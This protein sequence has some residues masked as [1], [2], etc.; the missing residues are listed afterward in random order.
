MQH[1]LGAISIDSD[2]VREAISELNDKV[3]LTPEGIPSRFIKKTATGLCY[4]LCI[5]FK[6]SIALGIVPNA[7]KTAIV[8]P[9][10]KKPPLNRVSNYR[11]ISLTSS[12]CKVLEIVLRKSILSH[13]S[14]SNIISDNQ[15]G[16]LKGKSTLTQLLTSCCDWYAGLN[17]GFQTDVVY[18]DF[19]KAFD[20]VT[21]PKLLLKLKAYGIGGSVLTWLK[22]FLCGRSFRVK[23]GNALSSS[24]FVLSGV[25]QGSL[26]GPLLFL[27]YVNDLPKSLLS[28]CKLYADDVKIYRPITDPQFDYNVLRP[29]MI[30][31]EQ[32]SQLWQLDISPEKCFVLHLNFS[33]ECPLHLCGFDLPAKE[34]MKDLGVYVSS[35]L[36]WH[37]HCVEVSRR[38]AQVA[39][40]ILRAVQYSSVE[41]YRKAFVA[42]CRPILEYCTQVW[43]PSVKRDIEMIERVQRRFTKMAFRKAFRGPF[44]PNYEQRLRIFDL[45]PLWYRRTQ[46]DLHLCFKIVKGFSGIPFK[47]IFSF[48]KFASRSRFH[49]LQIERKT[50]SRID[51]LNSFA[52][53]VVP[54]W[55][56][57]PCDVVMAGNLSCFKRRLEQ[58]DLTTIP[59]ACRL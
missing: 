58:C 56:S 34:V 49:L 33:T 20:S 39:N 36:N 45:K 46:F 28:C 10:P 29:D 2:I 27:L 4:P 54:I 48:A 30:S 42:Y 17:N 55:N 14:L 59:A 3:S 35:D 53:R 15:H 52:F 19:A 37:N 31:L 32:W 9:L 1:H 43:S 26:L 6:H 24:H 25:P 23:V 13:L 44:Q 5:L 11:P 7:W 21:H 16:F 38:A 18:I 40:Y 8:I 57:L 22:N 12:F 47:S 41:S 50:T 51:V